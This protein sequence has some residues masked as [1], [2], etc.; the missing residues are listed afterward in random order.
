M[1]LPVLSASIEKHRYL[2]TAWILKGILLSDL[3]KCGE[4]RAR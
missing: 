3:L 2:M 1:E 4:G